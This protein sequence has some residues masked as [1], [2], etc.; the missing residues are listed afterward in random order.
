MIY[1]PIYSATSELLVG[2]HRLVFKEVS[3]YDL[4]PDIQTPI[5]ATIAGKG[6]VIERTEKIPSNGTY[7]VYFDL[8]NNPIPV[9]VIVVGVLVV[10]GLSLTVMV[11]DRVDRVIDSSHVGELV[12]TVAQSPVIIVLI[13]ALIGI[14]AIREFFPKIIPK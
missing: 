8:K 6:L 9:M 1:F 13:V 11:F 12:A 3:N 4:L 7:F 10:L 5:D 14:F 2:K